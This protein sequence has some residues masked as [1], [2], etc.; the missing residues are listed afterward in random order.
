MKILF[1]HLSD[2]HIKDDKGVNLF[3]INKI[4]DSL[5]TAGSCDYVTIILSG[6]IAFSGQNHQYKQANKI[7]GS[8]INPIKKTCNIDKIPVWVVPG[9]HDINQGAVPLTTSELQEIYNKS[10][11]EYEL[12]NEVDKQKDFYNFAKRS[13]A[14]C[15]N[16]VIDQ[17]VFDFGGYKVEFNLINTAMF[18]LISGEDK[19]LHYIPT[20][21]INKIA[22]PTNAN[23]VVSI[24]HQAPDWLIDSQKLLL[25]KEVMQKS[26]LVFLGHEHT[27]GTK[28]VSINDKKSA[29]IYAGGLLCNN[30]DWSS[31]EFFIGVFDTSDNQYTSWGFKWNNDEKQYEPQKNDSVIL[32]VKPS[33]EKKLTPTNEF[34]LT[35]FSDPNYDISKNCG[36]YFVFPRIQLDEKDKKIQKEFSNEESFLT[37]ILEKKKIMITGTYN[38]GKS[39]LL[40]HL[41][42]LLSKDKTVLYCNAEQI[43]NKQRSKVIKSV[44]ED[45]YGEDPSDYIRFQQLS[46][47][48]KVLI[49]DDVDRIDSKQLERFV[50]SIDDEFGILIF[51]TKQIWEFDIFETIKKSMSDNSFNK[52]KIMSIYFDKREELIEKLVSL[53]TTEK[54]DVKKITKALVAAINNQKKFFTLTP[55]FIIQYVEVYFKNIDEFSSNDGNV[56]GK[57]FEANLVNAI[58]KH[59]HKSLSVDKIFLILSKIAYSIH[60]SDPKK[61]P[62]T[63]EEI[64]DIIECYNQKYDADVNT[65]TIIKNAVDSRIFSLTDDEKYRFGNKNVLAYFVAKE[66]ISKYNDDGNQSNLENVLRLSCFGINSDIL[67]FIIYLTDNTRILNLLLS[68]AEEFTKDWVEYDAT[69]IS[70]NFMKLDY[71]HKA[72]MPDQSHQK[73]TEEEIIKDERKNDEQIVTKDFYDYAEEDA[74]IFT[75]KLFRAV[76]IMVVIAKCLPNFEHMMIKETKQKFTELVYKL[77]NQIF[78]F[79][80]SEVEKDLDELLQYLKEVTAPEY[81]NQPK[82]QEADSLRMIQW[83]AMSLLLELYNASLT[84]AAKETSYKYLDEYEHVQKITNRLQHVMLT[85]RQ[86]SPMKFIKEAENILDETKDPLIKTLIKRIV[87]HAYVFSKKLDQPNRQRIENKFFADS[88]KKQLLLKR[89]TSNKDE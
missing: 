51:S 58:N 18:S 60:F 28:M 37:E 4:V 16:S 77:P 82:K 25:E 57:V 87:S 2:L 61:H 56:F 53:K 55:D 75:N 7:I 40:K 24:M 67:L 59:S 43:G 41:Y 36:D 15:N 32:P 49:F 1:L 13:K 89:A 5:S 52:Y 42:K 21:Q 31:S 23:L 63:K 3:Q 27:M 47:D 17:R 33:K 30:E 12:A 83:T 38:S 79:W 71:E 80:A 44:F 84:N 72:E 86:G 66:V 85:E 73:A 76:S 70:P 10:T 54:D 11:Y 29:R 74:E 81:K 64:R 34:S 9:N 48:K 65:E 78:N 39:M 68:M 22:T 8:I 45:I 20:H 6:D 62:I 19:G 14:F 35:L 88:E 69:D 50:N 26:S 46:K